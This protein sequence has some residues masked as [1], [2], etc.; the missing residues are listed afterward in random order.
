MDIMAILKGGPWLLENHCLVLKTWI[1]SFKFDE[2]VMCKGLV[3]LAFPNLAL[4]FW[5][6]NSLSKTTSAVGLPL[7]PTHFATF[8]KRIT[9]TKILIELIYPFNCVKL[10]QLKILLAI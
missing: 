9:Y 10:Y 4:S 5:F 7:F 2:R 3:W 1:P 6:V 8:K